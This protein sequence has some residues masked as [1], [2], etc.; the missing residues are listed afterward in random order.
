[1]KDIWKLFVLSLQH[2]CMA[3]IM[4]KI[5]ILS[6][7]NPSEVTNV[8]EKVHS[9]SA[10]FTVIQLCTVPFIMDSSLVPDQ[11]PPED[12]DHSVFLEHGTLLDGGSEVRVNNTNVLLSGNFYCILNLKF[13]FYYISLI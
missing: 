6:K 4:S 3:E 10:P 5:K 13:S 12:G 7:R 9:L 2:F 8:N 1:M 11:V